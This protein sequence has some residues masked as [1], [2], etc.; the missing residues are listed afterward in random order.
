MP[1]SDRSDPRPP[2]SGTRGDASAPAEIPSAADPAVGA[3]AAEV[4]AAIRSY[5]AVLERSEDGRGSATNEHLALEEVARIVARERDPQRLV[6]ACLRKSV[7][8]LDLDIVRL[9]RVGPGEGQLRLAGSHGGAPGQA[10]RE[11]LSRSLDAFL[12]DGEHHRGPVTVEEVVSGPANGH[13]AGPAYVVLSVPIFN[14]TELWGVFQAGVVGPR[15]FTSAEAGVIESVAGLVG[16]GVMRAEESGRNAALRSQVERKNHR[17]VDLYHRLR[18]VRSD[19]ERKNRSLAEAYGH[20]QGVEKMKDAF[21]SSI[22]HEMRTPL[23]IIRSYVDLLLNYRPDSRE[24]EEEFLKV[25]D[26]EA[27]KLIAQINKILHLTEIRGNEVRLRIDTHP[28]EEIVR[29]ALDEVAPLAAEKRIAIERRLAAGLPNLLIDR[30]KTIRILADIL[31]NA[32]KFSPEGATVTLGSRETPGDPSGPYVTFWVSDSGPGVDP[33]FQTR[34]F[35]QFSQV[36]DLASGKPRGIGLGLPICRAYV[37]QMG[38]KI[39]LESEP[40]NGS[41]FFVALPVSRTPLAV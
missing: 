23:T 1:S 38:G 24:K 10:E 15:R 21:V 7:T 13:G 20:L 25:V 11:S 35:E 36:A 22:S 17:I 19:L 33:E 8:F 3:G 32:I 5:L 9:Y 18:D 4:A 16:T 27:I 39:W 12:R 40:G 6:A 29:S 28:V 41:T 34:I 31:D 30:E 2:A 26:S 14:G 37:E